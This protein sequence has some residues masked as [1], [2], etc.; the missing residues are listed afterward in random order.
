MTAQES[1]QKKSKARGAVK[2]GKIFIQSTY[3]NTI[4]S[5]TDL[6]GNVLAQSSAGRVGFGGTRKSTPYAAQKAVADVLE[7][8]K[9]Y[10]L[11][12]A[13]VFVRGIGSAREAAVR[14][15]NV[16]GLTLKSIRDITPI[17]HNGVRA[18]KRRRV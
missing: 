6:E 8:V 16:A 11:T 4:I 1:K 10:G 12:E 7:K 9:P 18:P 3:N 13:A 14:S 17:P 5:I 2:Q 15:L